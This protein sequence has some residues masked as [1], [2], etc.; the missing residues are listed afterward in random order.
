VLGHGG[1]ADRT[2]KELA[3]SYDCLLVSKD[4]DFIRVAI[5]HGAPPKFVWI[6]QGNCPTEEIARLLRGHRDEIVRF[7]EQNEATVLDLR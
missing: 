6:R 1:A 3:R 2:V 5:L 4:E 7:S